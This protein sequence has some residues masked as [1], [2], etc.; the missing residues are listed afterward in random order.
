MAKQKRTPV[1]ENRNVRRKEEIPPMHFIHVTNME[2]IRLE[3]CWSVEVQRELKQADMY[4]FVKFS[5]SL[6]DIDETLLKEYVRNYDVMDGTSTVNGVEIVVDQATLHEHCYLPISE[7]TVNNGAVVSDDFIPEEQFK[8]GQE[9]L[10]PKQGWRAADAKTPEL[11]EWLRFAAKR[12]TILRHATYL[13]KKILYAVVVTLRGMQLNWAAYVSTRIHNEIGLKRRSGRMGALLCSNYVSIIVRKMLLNDLHRPRKEVVTPVRVPES[14]VPQVISLQETEERDD[15]STPVRT[16]KG[17]QTVPSAPPKKK[18]GQTSTEDYAVKERLLVQL[19]QLRETM[20]G[21]EDVST[22]KKSLADAR[23][24][25]S[26]ATQGRNAAIQE[27]AQ[28]EAQCDLL[29][30]QI[31]DLQ[32]KLNNITSLKNIGDTEQMA[33][34]EALDRERAEADVLR[35]DKA[36]ILEEQAKLRHSLRM[37]N[38]ALTDKVKALETQVRNPIEVRVEAGPNQTEITEAART[39]KSNGRILELEE[40]VRQLGNINDELSQR[41]MELEEGSSETEPEDEEPPVREQKGA[42]E[43]PLATEPTVVNLPNAMAVVIEIE[44]EGNGTKEETHHI[45]EDAA[46]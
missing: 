38:Q 13:P 16:D 15:A 1:S 46:Q 39:E 44:Q 40:Q 36:A 22:L 23:S 17:K 11:V 29:R 27:K 9:A 7:V 12:L 19:D 6:P 45:C 25:A 31:V 34:R 37:E 18:Q 8:T 24:L 41:I 3:A 5:Q 4:G 20:L 43:P 28:V 33:L 2:P 14:T 26:V 42:N 21:M 30:R 35:K 32:E 10:D